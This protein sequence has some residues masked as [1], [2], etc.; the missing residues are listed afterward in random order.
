MDFLQVWDALGWFDGVLF[1]IWL[2]V[3]YYT[4]CWIDDHF[5][6]R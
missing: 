5:M 2:G 6:N 1:S 3:M 4:K